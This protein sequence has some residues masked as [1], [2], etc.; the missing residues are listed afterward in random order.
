MMTP[1]TTTIS[2]SQFLMFVVSN[3]IEAVKTA[4]NAQPDLIHAKTNDHFQYTP[5]H[6]ASQLGHTEIVRLLLQKGANIHE[7]SERVSWRACLLAAKHGHSQVVKMLLDRG[8]DVNVQLAYTKNKFT[9]LHFACQYGH[10]ELARMLLVDYKARIDITSAN[11]LRPIHTAANF[12][13]AEIV[14]LLLDAGEDIDIRHNSQWQ[15]TP[16]H[17]SVQENKIKTAELLV[18]R[19][20]DV[21]SIT[22]NTY[23]TPLIQCA[24]KNYPDLAKMLLELGAN[25]RAYNKSGL[26]AIHVAANSNHVETLKV[27]LD[28]LPSELHALERTGGRSYDPIRIAIASG[29]TNCVRELLARGAVTRGLLQWAMV[30]APVGEVSQLLLQHEQSMI[31]KRGMIMLE[32]VTL[33]SD[34]FSDIT[35]SCHV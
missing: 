14:S 31:E 13:N 19:G 8:E 23:L 22:G 30:V 2:K 11:G 9:C 21:N 17:W 28:I 10:V 25:Y 33:R 27:I 24:T 7:L 3:N 18:Q 4:L 35:I 1:T 5:L 32:C 6:R 15:Y 26:R 12:G 20:A 34:R 16:L 29:A